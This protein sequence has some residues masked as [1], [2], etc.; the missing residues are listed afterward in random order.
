MNLRA[1]SIELVRSKFPLFLLSQ[2][3]YE[4]KDHFRAI[5]I[6]FSGNLLRKNILVMDIGFCEQ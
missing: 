3:T 1:E 6:S 4:I 2:P 5:N